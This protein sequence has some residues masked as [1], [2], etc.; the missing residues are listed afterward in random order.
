FEKRYL[1]RFDASKARFRTFLRTCLDRFVQNQQKAA[2]RLKRGGGFHVQ[3]LD[4]PGAE[5]DIERVSATAAAADR[6]EFFRAETIRALFGRTIEAMRQA[7]ASDGR[8]IV[9]AVFERH[10]LAGD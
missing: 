10:D 7:C 3:S 2:Q 1:E 5:R 6:E 9:F 4:F 8:D